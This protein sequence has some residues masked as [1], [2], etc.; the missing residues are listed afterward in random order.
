[1]FVFLKKQT[2]INKNKRFIYKSFRF[3]NMMIINF[4]LAAIF[5]FYTIW[6]DFVNES[7]LRWIQINKLFLMRICLLQWVLMRIAAKIYWWRVL[8]RVSKC[9]MWFKK[10]DSNLFFVWNCLKRFVFVIMLDHFI[11]NFFDRLISFLMNDA[12]SFSIIE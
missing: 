3:E 5:F 8:C 7:L 2:I 6:W 11:V 12:C 1:V 9:E 4:S 10:C